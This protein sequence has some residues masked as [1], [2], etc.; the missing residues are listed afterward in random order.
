M[1]ALP[2]L[3]LVTLG[4]TACLGVE[5]AGIAA[6]ASV[7]V[8]EPF[9]VVAPPWNGGPEEVVQTAGGRLVGPIHAP[10]SVLAV[11][12]PA[13][14]FLSA[15]AWLVLDASKLLALCGSEGDPW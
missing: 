6:M 8:R 12:A 13:E 15:G 5:V 4:I 1:K 2:L 14:T 3:P 11:G 10:L 9:V 7:D